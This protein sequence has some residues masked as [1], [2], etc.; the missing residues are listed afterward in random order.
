MTNRV[1]S[2][3]QRCGQPL[4]PTTSAGLCPVCVLAAGSQYDYRIVNILAQGEHATVYVA[5]QQPSHRL[6]ALKIFKPDPD[7]ADVVERLRDQRHALAALAHPHMARVYDV[8]LMAERRPYVVSEYVRGAPITTYCAHSQGDR[9]TRQRLLD[10]VSDV[11][12]HV[13]RLGI[14][15]GGIKPSNILVLRGL[16]DPTV[17]VMDFGVRAAEPADDTAAFE[18]LVALL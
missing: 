4:V 12:G 5:E 16:G 10:I 7:A 17:K 6:V 3:C 18:R 11:I 2:V 15:H 14:T 13:H 1:D 9:P 8:G